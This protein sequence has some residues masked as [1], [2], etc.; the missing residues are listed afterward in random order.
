MVASYPLHFCYDQN[1]WQR[2]AWKVAQKQGR[3]FLQHI[4]PAIVNP[5]HSLW[6]Q[7]I[8]FLFLCMGTVFGFSAFRSLRAGDDL[9]GLVMCLS[10][11]LMAW[12]GISSFWRARKISRS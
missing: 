10:A 12:F 5:L 2:A 8:G 7:V 3:G 9:R 11:A 6:N 1:V 4:V